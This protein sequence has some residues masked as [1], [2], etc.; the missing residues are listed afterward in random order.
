M[1]E[2]Q[3]DINILQHI[4]TYC[5]EIQETVSR[6]GEDKELFLHDSVYHNAVALCIL[7]IGELVG[8]LSDEFKSIHTEI[9]WRD[10][11]LM[12]NIVAHRYGTV[13][14]SITWDVVMDDIPALKAFCSSVLDEDAALKK[15]IK[16][17]E[18]KGYIGSVEFSEAD[19]VFFG[20]VKGI[21]SLISY[22]GKTIEALKRDFHGAVDDYL[23]PGN[24]K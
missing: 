12:R 23:K 5:E 22:E 18:Y 3:R 10:I 20:K 14:H 17:M 11:K 16:E 24:E 15:T 8:I 1:S 4:L 19:G 21:S 7:Q 2:N 13:D 6:F 9:P